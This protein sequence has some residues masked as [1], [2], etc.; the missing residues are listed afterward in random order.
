MMPSDR[1][2]KLWGWVFWGCVGL[3]ALCGTLA[4]IFLT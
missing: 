1:A 2:P 3:Y 4:A